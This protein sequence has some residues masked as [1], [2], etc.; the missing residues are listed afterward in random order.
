V[1]ARSIRRRRRV[2]AVVPLAAVLLVT[3]CGTDDPSDG[4]AAV[5]ATAAVPSSPAPAPE[6]SLDDAAQLEQDNVEAAEQLVVDYWATSAEVGARAYEDWQSAFNPLVGPNVW[7]TYAETWAE[8]EAEGARSE[9]AVEVDALTVTAYEPSDNGFERVTLDACTD[10]SGITGFDGDGTP[11]ERSA[12]APLRYTTE[13]VLAHQGVGAPW[14]V[15][16][17]TPRPEETC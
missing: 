17:M 3:G 15:A 13:Y 1:A 16:E 14:V 2:H 7:A 5:L 12:D 11:H 8:R 4:E 10:Y 6:P 9:G